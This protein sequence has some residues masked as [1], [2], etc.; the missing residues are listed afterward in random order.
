MNDFATLVGGD[1]YELAVAEIN[2]IHRE[3]RARLLASYPSPAAPRVGTGAGLP[4]AARP[5]S[6]GLPGRRRGA[7]TAPATGGPS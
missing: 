5:P 3:V 1:Q 2:A 7:G 6:S 4:P